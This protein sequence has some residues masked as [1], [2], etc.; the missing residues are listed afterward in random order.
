[1]EDGSAPAGTPIPASSNGGPVPGSTDGAIAA[2]I[3][4][5]NLQP[6][7]ASDPGAQAL[8]NGLPDV[9]LPCLG[10]G[11][12][13]RLSGLR[14][15]P[16]VVNVWQSYCAPCLAE[17]PIMAGVA[18]RAS[19]KLMFLGIDYQDERLGALRMAAKTQMSFPS[20]QDPARN[21]GSRLRIAGVPVTFFVRAD[22]T[23]AGRAAAAFSDASA[24]EQQIEQV[25]GVRVT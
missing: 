12:A 16:M 1:M 13:V 15:T 3:S 4:A 24:L 6:C 7:P 14:G 22:G 19:G 10:N 11:P 20:V 2:D 18:K 23:I 9:V 17:L 5:A 21:V 25:L 8:E